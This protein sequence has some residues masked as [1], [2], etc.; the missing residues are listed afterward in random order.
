MALAGEV[1]TI[2]ER[3]PVLKWGYILMGVT[4]SLAATLFSSVFVFVVVDLLIGPVFGLLASLLT[5]ALLL[6][7]ALH[8]VYLSASGKK[9][10]PFLGDDPMQHWPTHAK[11]LMMV[12][13]YL[14][15]GFAIYASWSAFEHKRERAHCVSSCNS[16]Q[17]V[18]LPHSPMSGGVS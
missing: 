4:L 1:M 17:R 18:V 3:R 9:L 2:E 12:L 15:I 5:F 8:F 10:I 16:N 7:R 13:A 6:V 14:L 11:F